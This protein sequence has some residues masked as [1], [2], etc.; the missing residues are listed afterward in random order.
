MQRS[1]IRVRLLFIGYFAALHTGY[2]SFCRT[3]RRIAATH[4][5]VQRDIYSHAQQIRIHKRPRRFHPCGMCR[6]ASRRAN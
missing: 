5:H 4:D 1:A 2:N 3:I 6:I